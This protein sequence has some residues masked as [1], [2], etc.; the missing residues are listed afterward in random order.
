MRKVLGLVI[1][2]SIFGCKSDSETQILEL[3][4]K[5]Q[6]FASNEKFEEAIK[7]LNEIEKIEPNYT[8]G[9]FRTRNIKTFR[10]GCSRIV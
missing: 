8:L 6:E 5:S 7:A 9:T 4:K 3:S 2:I 10:L 1:F